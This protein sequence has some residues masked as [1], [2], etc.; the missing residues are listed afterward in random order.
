MIFE[1]KIKDRIPEE[2]Y[3]LRTV[4]KESKNKNRKRLLKELSIEVIDSLIQLKSKLNPTNVFKKSKNEVDQSLLQIYR[5]TSNLP[6]RANI[7]T[8][9]T[10]SRAKTL[11]RKYKNY[12]KLRYSNQENCSCINNPMNPYLSTVE[13]DRNKIDNKHSFKNNSYS[14][15]KKCKHCLQKAL[16]S[17][18]SIDIRPFVDSCDSVDISS[19][20]QKKNFVNSKE[21]NKIRNTSRNNKRYGVFLDTAGDFT[22]NC[23]SENCKHKLE[24][25]FV[26]DNDV[27]VGG[28]I[29]KMGGLQLESNNEHSIELE[30]CDTF[31]LYSAEVGGLSIDFAS[32]VLLEIEKVEKKSIITSTMKPL[33]AYSTGNNSI[34]KNENVPILTP[35]HNIQR[36]KGS[37]GD[38]YLKSTSMVLH[39]SIDIL[40]AR[41]YPKT[42]MKLGNKSYVT[43]P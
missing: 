40:D 24:L 30:R 2:D 22:K 15:K 16:E 20:T 18:Q 6:V 19:Y 13:I 8:F 27:E 9:K 32:Q 11:F 36:E 23:N 7:S 38:L 28:I 10:K 17:S 42:V 12:T 25:D 35:N 26:S 14:T 39:N 3:K 34:D 33:R 41:I 43:F 1:R 5:S 21:K 4:M 29:Q 37:I 31:G